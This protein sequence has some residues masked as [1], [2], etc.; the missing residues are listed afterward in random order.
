[1]NEPNSRRG[2]A[3]LLTAI[4]AAMTAGAHDL[5]KSEVSADPTGATQTLNI[6][7]QTDTTGAFFQSLGING[8]SG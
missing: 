4:F 6:N 7:G 5:G 8:R 3:S 1:M 2:T